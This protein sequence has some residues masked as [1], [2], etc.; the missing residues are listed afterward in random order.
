MLTFVMLMSLGLVPAQDLPAALFALGAGFSCKSFSKMHKDFQ[1]FLTAM[2]DN[3]DESQSTVIIFQ[4]Q[5]MFTQAF[6]EFICC[7]V[8]NSIRLGCTLSYQS[9]QGQLIGHDIQVRFAAAA[10]C[11]CPHF[12][13]GKCRLRRDFQEHKQRIKPPGDPT[14]TFRSARWL[15]CSCF[16]NSVEGFWGASKESEIIFHRGS[17]G[18]LSKF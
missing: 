7:Q 3:S 18:H 11:V 12:P 15:P 13:V 5:L 1:E 2:A 6:F 16:Q 17:Q 4:L 10:D 9:Y 8:F 14:C